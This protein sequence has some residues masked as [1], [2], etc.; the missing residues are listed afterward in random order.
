[1]LLTAAAPFAAAVFAAEQE[2]APLDFAATTY[3]QDR[4]AR[5]HGAYGANY[6]LQHMAQ[7]SDEKLREVI[8]AMA[9]GPG[10]APLEA[11]QLEAQTAYHRSMMDGKPFLILTNRI[12]PI[13]KVG[14]NQAAE[15]VQIM[16]L[17]HFW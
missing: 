3:F 17:A 5:C 2:A 11:R 8:A 14:P 15:W 12:A 7:S 1:M 6:N 4:C 13:E 10:Q 9:D 16:A